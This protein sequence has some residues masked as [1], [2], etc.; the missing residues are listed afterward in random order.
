MYKVL[1]ETGH[2]GIEAVRLQN[3]TVTNDPKV[4]LKDVLKSFQRQRNTEDEELLLSHLPKLE[5]CTAPRSPFRNWMK[6]CAN[7]NREKPRG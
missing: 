6:Y 3:S 2:R 5:T 1:G 7:Y 4:V